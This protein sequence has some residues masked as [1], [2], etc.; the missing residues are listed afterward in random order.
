MWKA[1]VTL[2]VMGMKSMGIRGSFT[3]GVKRWVGGG[4]ICMDIHLGPYHSSEG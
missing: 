1:V 4:R 2:K 3:F